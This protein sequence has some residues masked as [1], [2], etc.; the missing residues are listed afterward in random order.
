MRAYVLALAAVLGLSGCSKQITQFVG[1]GTLPAPS[2]P[3]T[4]KL[5]TNSVRITAGAVYG[6]ASAVE[7]SLSLAPTNQ[8]VS[9]S[10]LSGSLSLHK[11]WAQ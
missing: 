10:Q 8:P 9:G 6:T 5:G 2:T 7:A 3:S 1:H 11:Q 4:A